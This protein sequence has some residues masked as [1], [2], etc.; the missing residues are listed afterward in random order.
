LTFVKEND[1]GTTDT[2]ECFDGFFTKIAEASKEV[3]GPGRTAEN[4][5]YSE[6][7]GDFDQEKIQE[8]L[9]TEKSEWPVTQ[10]DLPG[11]LVELEISFLSLMKEA[12]YFEDYEIEKG[13]RIGE[14]YQKYDSLWDMGAN[15][16]Y[17]VFKFIN[18]E[19]DDFFW[20]PN[21][22][23]HD[24]SQYT[25]RI[26]LDVQDDSDY[27]FEQVYAVVAFAGAFFRYTPFI[28]QTFAYSRDTIKAIE[29]EDA[30]ED[31]LTCAIDREVFESTY[32]LK[33]PTISKIIKKINILVF[34]KF[35]LPVCK[36]LKKISD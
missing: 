9:E 27:D 12:L 2:Y 17:A 18:V 8:Y 16:H 5:F 36:I 24:S 14:F 11:A 7:L 21:K 29:F 1:D 10:D 25:N 35:V 13:Y 22:V 20:G 31:P 32:K 28:Y 6:E 23:K 34:N 33:I 19:N 3:Y 26:S 4:P 15:D 30:S